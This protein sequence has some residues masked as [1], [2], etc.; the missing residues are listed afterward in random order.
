MNHDLSHM[1]YRHQRWLEVQYSKE[2]H[3]ATL[4]WES[5][6]SAEVSLLTAFEA[7]V[8]Y[9]KEGRSENHG[10]HVVLWDL[11]DETQKAKRRQNPQ[12]QCPMSQCLAGGTRQSEAPFF[13][14]TL[15]CLFLPGAEA[16]GG[17]GVEK[18]AYRN[19]CA[20]RV[21]TLRFQEDIVYVACP[22]TVG[23]RMLGG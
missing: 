17:A 18:R 11:L 21:Y 1:F 7:R 5:G 2:A 9:C 4:T 6:Q 10:V 19:R 14:S 3:S 12:V 8:Y 16:G 15:Y 22:Q 13:R 20:R 23:Q